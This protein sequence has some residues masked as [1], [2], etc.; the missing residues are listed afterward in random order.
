MNNHGFTQKEWSDAKREAKE[1]LATRAKVRGMIPYSDLV[2]RIK[3]VRLEAH[4]QRLF[5]LLGEISEEE[6]D[7]GRGMLSVI[8]VHKTG[9]MQPGPGFFDLAEQLGRNTSDILKCWID[10][11]KK[12][13]AYWSSATRS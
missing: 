13:H 7:A 2:A 6:D 8:V 12:V 3:S 4:D 11:L 1:I 5:H 9:D 10:E